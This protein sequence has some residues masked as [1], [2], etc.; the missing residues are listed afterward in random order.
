[1]L[2][3]KVVAQTGPWAYHL[4]MSSGVCSKLVDGKIAVVDESGV[5]DF[6]I[7][8]GFVTGQN[9]RYC[10]GCILGRRWLSCWT[11]DVWLEESY[12]REKEG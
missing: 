8:N 5:P 11:G 9:D 10:R 1:M 4:K 7:S 6:Y 2:G 12:G 3:E